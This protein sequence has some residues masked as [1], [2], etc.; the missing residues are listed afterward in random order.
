MYLDE[1]VKS[2]SDGAFR[3][4]MDACIVRLSEQ[5]TVAITMLQVERDLAEHSRIRAI[6]SVRARLGLGLKEAKDLVDREVPQK[7]KEYEPHPDD[8]W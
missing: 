7:P 2:L 3:A 8:R 5:R 6:K 4:L 1:F